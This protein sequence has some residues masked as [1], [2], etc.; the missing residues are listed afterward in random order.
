MNREHRVFCIF[1]LRPVWPLKSLWYVFH[2]KKLTY[3]DGSSIFASWE[4]IN[5][6]TNT[7]DPYT[8]LVGLYKNFN[9]HIK[10]EIN[11]NILCRRRICLSY[12]E[13]TIKSRSILFRRRPTMYA[14][15]G[16]IRKNPLYCSW[17]YQIRINEQ[18][19]DSIRNLGI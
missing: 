3:T 8:E 9:E 4:N 13:S 6:V 2:E 7:P 19:L 15:F 10:F 12:Y 18:F 17:G 5:W 1:H 14:V 11:C 16:L